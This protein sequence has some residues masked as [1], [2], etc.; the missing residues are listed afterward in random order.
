MVI[1]NCVGNCDWFDD[2]PH[3]TPHES[4]LCVTNEGIR[5]PETMSKQDIMCTSEDVCPTTG[6]VV[7]C[8]E[9]E[10]N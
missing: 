6:Y 7:K 5:H 2:C 8:I 9:T 3:S 10:E 1:C 4:M